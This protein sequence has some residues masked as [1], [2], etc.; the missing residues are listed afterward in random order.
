MSLPQTAVTLVG[1]GEDV[2]RKLPHLVFAVQV[3]GVGVIQAR[4][5]LVGVHGG[6]DGADVG[7]RETRTDC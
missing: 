2:R 4:Y 3:D 5:R 7:L 1:H 6:Q